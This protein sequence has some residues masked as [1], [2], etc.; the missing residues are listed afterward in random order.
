MNL[1][2]RKYKHQIYSILIICVICMVLGVLLHRMFWR[3]TICFGHLF[4]ELIFGRDYYSLY[5]ISILGILITVVWEKLWKKGGAHFVLL[6]CCA[7]LVW[8]CSL[9]Y[10]H[11]KYDDVLRV[12]KNHIAILKNNKIGIINGWGR[13]VIAVEYDR[14][15]ECHSFNDENEPHDK[16]VC[17]LR[18]GNDYYTLDIHGQLFITQQIR[19][20]NTLPPS[21]NL[22][23]QDNKDLWEYKFYDKKALL[24]MIDY[25]AKEMNSN[26]NS[27]LSPYNYTFISRTG[28]IVGSGQ[29]FALEVFGDN[30]LYL[31]DSYMWK[32][33]GLCNSGRIEVEGEVSDIEKY[34]GAIELSSCF[35]H[36]YNG[37][38][39]ILY[40][41]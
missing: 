12:G 14:I 38:T 35:E 18:K 2:L 37:Q 24:Y 41:E 7:I 10:F 6:F 40:E 39:Y 17:M 4:D 27:A 5:I 31:K 20:I 23:K 33:F 30:L 22:R 21:L 34:M 1:C 36:N 26:V 32:C 29:E 8:T 11:W 28:I 9:N 19:E 15:E 16:F 13:E 25:G 3:V